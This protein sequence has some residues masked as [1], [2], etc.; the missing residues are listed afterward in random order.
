MP[1]NEIRDIARAMDKINTIIIGAGVVGLA[2]ARALTLK[3]IECLVLEAE[4]DVGTITSAR[5]SGV[6]HAGFYY[7]TGSFKARFCVAGNAA[8]Y[9]YAT[10]RGIPHKRCGKLVVA[11]ADDQIPKLQELLELGAANAV[12]D[13]RM[14]DIA[15][16]HRMEPNVRMV[17]ALWSPNTGIIDVHTYIHSLLGDVENGGGMVALQAPVLSVACT[18]D[19]FVLQVGGASPTEILC[20]RL[21]NA[22]GLGAQKVAHAIDELDQQHIPPLVLAKGSYFSLSAPSPFTHLVYPVPVM[23]SLG[24]HASSD[25]GGRTR[26][27]PDIEWVDAID[28]SVHGD[29]LPKFEA[30]I[31]DYW[32]GLPAGSL[33]PEYC[34]IRP[35]TAKA[36]HKDTDF[37]ISDARTHGI[38]NLIN[39][40]GIESPGLTSSLAIGDYVAGLLG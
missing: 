9:R 16:A 7:K 36:S 12:P 39:L 26:F 19:G 23:G 27:G 15:E 28:Y 29:H 20:T 32:P 35:K 38:P 8:L 18:A 22:A 1:D 31:R 21:I 24:L 33:A 37:I 34:G 40:F 17:A 3:G 2:I 5:N 6:I 25:L 14:L 10:E 13:L 30:A 11:T 4:S